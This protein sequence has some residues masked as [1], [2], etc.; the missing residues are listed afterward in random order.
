MGW[1]AGAALNPDPRRWLNR[2]FWVGLPPAVKHP[3]R[4]YIYFFRGAETRRYSLNLLTLLFGI[5]EMCHLQHQ[6]EK[7]VNR[8]INTTQIKSGTQDVGDK[9]VFR[10]FK[11]QWA[12]SSTHSSLILKP[13]ITSVGQLISGCRCHGY[14]TSKWST[15]GHQCRR[16]SFVRAPK[17]V[18]T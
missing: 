13:E 11:A 16:V 3:M 14:H 2:P 6:R 8:P 5:T 17:H 12:V 7:L 15:T 10:A 18:C 4:G 9:W 1:P